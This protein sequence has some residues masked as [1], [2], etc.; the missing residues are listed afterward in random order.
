MGNHDTEYR[1]VKKLVKLLEDSSLHELKVKLHDTSVHLVKNP[2][3]A[4]M[5]AQHTQPLFADLPKPAPLEVVQD[6]D[7]KKI[8]GDPIISP[9]VGTFYRSPSPDLDAFVKEGDLVKEGD[10]LCIVEA[11]KMMNHIK[12]SQSGRVGTIL[13]Q[14]GQP[15]EYGQHLIMIVD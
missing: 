11:M 3:Q 13:V 6:N 10:V 7:E 8:A 12:A 4:G 14:D 2:R 9:M 1:L 5:I 15:V